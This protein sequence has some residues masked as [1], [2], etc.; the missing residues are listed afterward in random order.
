MVLPSGMVFASEMVTRLDA[1]L[2]PNSQK[3]NKSNCMYN[4]FVRRV[5]VTNDLVNHRDT[6]DAHV[7][8]YGAQVGQHPEHSSTALQQ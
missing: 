1:Q 4:C 8:Q 5:T 6:P 2:L 7:A 3:Q